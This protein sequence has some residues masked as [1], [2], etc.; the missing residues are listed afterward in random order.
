MTVD[1]IFYQVEIGRMLAIGYKD[2]IIV[3]VRHFTQSR[4]HQ[5][6][7][8]VAD[9]GWGDKSNDTIA[10]MESAA[11][12][13]MLDFVLHP[14]DIGYADGDEH[15]WDVFGRKIEK[16]TSHIPYMTVQ[17]N[18]EQIWWN[19]TGYKHR[20]WMPAAQHGAPAG[21]TYYSLNIDPAGNAW[22]TDPTVTTDFVKKRTITYP[23]CP[24]TV[25]DCLSDAGGQLCSPQLTDTGDVLTNLANQANRA[26]WHL[27]E[28]FPHAST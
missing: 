14:G 6:F 5:S 3:G 18:H 1:C 27:V 24:A 19:A 17:G 20:W 10:H 9:M 21:A 13:G 8:G 2:C 23:H 25:T 22:T 7:I 26:A 28:P 11:A 16:V 12:A 15:W 4:N